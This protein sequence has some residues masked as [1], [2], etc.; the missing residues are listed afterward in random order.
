MN[1]HAC[2]ELNHL[3]SRIL[4]VRYTDL[5]EEKR[6]CEE[7]L[8]RT[9]KDEDSYGQIFAYT[10]LGDYYIAMNEVDAAGTHLIKALTMC[11][12]CK[13]DEYDDIRLRIYSLLGIYYEHKGDGQ[14][15]IQY[16]LYADAVARHVGDTFTECMILNNIAFS[17]QRHNGAERALEFYMEAYDLQR[18]LAD[19]P[20][21]LLL[22]NNLVET[23]ISLG[24]MEEAWAFMGEYE[25]VNGDPEDKQ[26]LLRNNMC[27]YYAKL[28]N[29]EECMKW[30][31]EILANLETLESDRMMA[32]ENYTSFF[33]AMMD[34]GH[35]EYAKK[36]LDCMERAS[37]AGGIDQKRI[38]EKNRIHYCL[39]F[40]DEAQHLAAYERFYIKM[41]EFKS[42]IDKTITDAMKAMI[43]L[44]KLKKSTEKVRD[45][46]DDLTRTST[47]DELTGIY[48]RGYFDN[49]ILQYS[50]RS[51][52]NN[53]AIIMLDVDYFK[54]YNDFYKHHAGD[55]VLME[56]AACLRDNQVEGVY[57]CRYGGD[58]FVCVCKDLDRDAVIDYIDTVRSCLNKKAIA[59]EESSC[60]NIITLSIGFA[61]G[62]GQEDAIMIMEAADRA[63]YESK[64]AGRN[65]VT[66]KRVSA[67]V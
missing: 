48:N 23:F 50:Q 8:D 7:L 11:E 55:K 18:K 43:Y 13:V 2:Y 28:G 51:D 40:E 47:I 10:F 12:D 16:Y 33:G 3:M 59:H 26:R 36:F 62:D 27:L 38:L 67:D 22:I 58:E 52:T 60:S 6:L 32:F 29:V 56:V 15:S 24:S 19:S 53:F 46:H 17:F 54:E 34:I 65:A 66:E 31:E 9:E 25:T 64:K 44:R 5:E 30:T 49:A 41:Q 21:K 42:E 57:P 37:G 14:S 4:E 1:E 39:K 61:F 45:E 35:K 20:I 63:L